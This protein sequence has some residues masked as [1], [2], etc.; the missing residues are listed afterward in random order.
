MGRWS[1]GVMGG[2]DV[3]VCCHA[4]LQLC[5]PRFCFDGRDVGCKLRVHNSRYDE[6]NSGDVISYDPVKKAHLVS[7]LSAID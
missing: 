2:A 4:I 6:W 5:T 7:M 3:R 1:D